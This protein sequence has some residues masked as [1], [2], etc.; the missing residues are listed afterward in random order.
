M[1]K[2]LQKTFLILFCSTIL[3]LYLLSVYFYPRTRDEFY[4]LSGE[5]NVFREYINS[6]FYV[7][8]RIGQFFSN[9]AGRYLIFKI[10]IS[11]FIFSSFFYLLFKFVFRTS[12][13]WKD[14]KDLKKLLLISGV[15]IFLIGYFGELFF[16][17]PY[18]TNYTLMNV[19][20][21]IYI[22]IVTE[23]FIYKRNYFIQYKIP[24][25]FILLFG[26]FIGLGNEHVPPVLLLL[27]GL[28]GLLEIIKNKKFTVPSKEISSAFVG[29]C[30]GYLLLFFAPANKVRLQKEGK[31]AF[32][33]NFL[34]YTNHLKSISKLYYHYNIEL[35]FFGVFIVV[36]LFFS[37]K[38]FPRQ[39]TLEL[40][41]YLLMAV[42]GMMITAYSPIVGTRLLFFSNVLFIFSGLIILLRNRENLFQNEKK[43]NSL[44][45]LPILFIIFYFTAAFAI[46]L[47]ANS[48]Y[49]QV[50][51]E[52]QKHSKT[53]GDVTIEK[54][55]NYKI[56]FLG[57]F[58]RKVLLDTGESYI[59]SDPKNK[60]SME[61]NII[62]FYKI[63]S[64]KARK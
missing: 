15:F 29:I 31:S 28:Y 57:N 18:S 16:Y 56:N 5:S 62:N 55:F 4:Y 45:L 32:A 24:L 51:S 17:I 20:Y 46:T 61:R 34:D 6:Y 60:T 53:N 3:L 25:F 35:L 11:C 12:F 54:T 48:N 47:K 7:N 26:I 41:S 23:Y 50:M 10:I 21:L 27:T 39:L 40:V 58:N 36:F 37:K 1:N 8:A 38:K 2:S 14:V 22:Y 63:N 19:F 33:F 49:F 30:V 42:V 43:L 13:S 64:L 52:I 44:L 59:D 9:L